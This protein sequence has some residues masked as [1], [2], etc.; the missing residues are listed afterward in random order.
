WAMF[1][2]GATLGELGMSQAAIESYDRLIQKFQD[3]DEPT[4]AELVARAMFYKGVALYKL[5]MPQ[6]A[7][8]QYDMLI[9]K[10]EDRNEPTIA[11]W[12]AKAKGNKQD[13]L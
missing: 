13:I 3:H 10:F 4:I 9:Q 8:E 6:P 2:K 7:I 11:K 12:V 5:G 1:N